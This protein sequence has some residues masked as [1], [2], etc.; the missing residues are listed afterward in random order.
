MKTVKIFYDTETTGTKFWKHSLH[1]IAGLIEVNGVVV[2]EFDLRVRPHPNAVI[3]PSALIAGNVTEEQIMGY[4]PMKDMLPVF[5]SILDNYVDRFDRASKAFL[6]GYNNSAFDD[7]F[8]RT[9]FELCGN[10]FYGAYFW[11]GPLDAMVLAAEYLKERRPQMPS[12][13]L[14]R[15]CTELGIP[16]DKDRIHESLYDAHLTREIYQIVTGLRDELM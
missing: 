13:K 10:R 5:T 14:H 2:E 16:V 15:V 4:A 8:L 3:D 1:Q 7:R 9:W 12:F 11:S 6:V